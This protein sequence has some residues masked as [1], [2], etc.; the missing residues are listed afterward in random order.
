MED[1]RKVN[2]EYPSPPDPVDQIIKGFIQLF[3]DQKKEFDEL[4]DMC[5]KV[6]R[7]V[8]DL[9]EQL[10]E[11]MPRKAVNHEDLTKKQAT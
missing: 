6:L 7:R 11:D 2:K 4:H 10:K 9:E 1:I 3:N 8:S 5:E